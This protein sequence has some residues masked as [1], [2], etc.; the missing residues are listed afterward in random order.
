MAHYHRQG[1]EVSDVGSIESY[2]VL[3]INGNEEIHVEVKGSS[4]EAESVELTGNEVDHARTS[5]T[6]LVVVDRIEWWRLPDGA[7][8]TAG[9]RARRWELWSPSDA[10][11][12]P[13]RYRYRLI[14][15][16]D[17]VEIT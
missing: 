14:N 7:V 2:D 3:A 5:N 6:H 15:H 10:L 8:A 16:V 4:G 12:R 13:T 11:L 17:E 1:Y 9:G